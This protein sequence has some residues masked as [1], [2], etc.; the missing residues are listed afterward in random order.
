MNNSKTFCGSKIIQD[1]AEFLCT[2]S[3]VD[4]D[5]LKEYYGEYYGDIVNNIEKKDK[6]LP[7]K[8]ASFVKI[9]S[10][11]QRKAKTKVLSS[12]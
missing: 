7:L 2:I 6:V 1:L 12:G 9:V 10:Q 8:Y 3:E 5:A 11:K 4:F